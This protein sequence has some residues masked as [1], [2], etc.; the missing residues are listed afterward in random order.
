MT[1]INPTAAATSNPSAQ[2]SVIRAVREN[3]FEV[4]RGIEDYAETVFG[5]DSFHTALDALPPKATFVD[6]GAGTGRAIVDLLES[7]RVDQ[8]V[9]IAYARPEDA[10]LDSALG[11]YG[12]RFQYLSGSTIE[13]MDARGALDAFKGSADLVTDAFGAASY[14]RDL[15]GVLASE[16]SLAKPGG[17]VLV[18]IPTMYVGAGNPMLFTEFRIAS[19][20]EP[21]GDQGAAMTRWLEG[22]KGARVVSSSFEGFNDFSQVFEL[23][24]TA[25]PLELPPLR[26]IEYED[27]CSPPH[28]V[29]EVQG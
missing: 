18:N 20:K 17:H 2:A 1:T 12:D 22:I 9:G 15:R 16:L 10:R 5:A 28:R 19:E 25:E 11:Q 21:A 3:D 24:R 13:E 6:V 14:T 23:E 4:R 7:S 27:F 8:A 26:L 29:Y